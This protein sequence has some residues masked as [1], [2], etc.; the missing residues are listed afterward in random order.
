MGLFNRLFAQKRE[1]PPEK[2]SESVEALQRY[3]RAIMNQ[4]GESQFQGDTQAKQILA[5]YCFGGVSAL[6][7]QHGMSQPRV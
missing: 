3:A 5:V 6:A 7:V 1:V 4:Y 2:I